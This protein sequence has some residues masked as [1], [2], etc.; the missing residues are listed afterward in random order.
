MSA[1][2]NRIIL[3]KLVREDK[4]VLFAAFTPKITKV[5]K[6]QLWEKIKAEAIAAGHTTLSKKTWE[7]VRDKAW[8]PIRRDYVAKRD[9]YRQSG[10][11]GGMGAVG[12]EVYI[13][14]IYQITAIFSLIRS[15]RKY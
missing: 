14:F 1:Q 3:A 11:E 12:T 4:D 8:G 6:Q 13:I 7:E 5:L 15:L 2:A 9:K 10:Y